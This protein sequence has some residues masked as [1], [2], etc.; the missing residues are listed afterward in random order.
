MQTLAQATL[1][2]T[3]VRTTLILTNPLQAGA[4]RRGRAAAGG[5]KQ[6]N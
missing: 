1:T 6:G 5:K 2:H 3:N 4:K